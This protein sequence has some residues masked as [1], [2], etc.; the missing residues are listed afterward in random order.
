MRAHR[1]K[2]ILG[3]LLLSISL[4]ML[5]VAPL[6]RGSDVRRATRDLANRPR[7]QEDMQLFRQY[8]M[9]LD[10]PTD[11]V[12][13]N[14]YAAMYGIFLRPFL[15]SASDGVRFL[16]IGLGCGMA[17]GPGASADLWRSVLPFAQLWISESDEECATKWSSDLHGLTVLTGDQKDPAVVQ[18]WIS[19]SGGSFDIVIDDGGHHNLM[20]YNSFV[21]LWPEVKPGG[22]Y[23]IEDMGVGRVTSYEDSNG[24]FVMANVIKDW[25]DQLLYMDD[26]VAHFKQTVSVPLII[27]HP[28]PSD[29]KFIF[30]QFGACVI[31]KCMHQEEPCSRLV[32]T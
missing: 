6:V 22:L 8:A 28:L 27:T 19:E 29:V 3:I 26:Y 9:G 24:E 18:K 2:Y 17:Y 15:G 10:K 13:Q 1:S 14:G 20:I 16:E 21:N 4:A 32:F 30:C 31:G 11:K 7:W 5:L 23:F 25:I 12:T